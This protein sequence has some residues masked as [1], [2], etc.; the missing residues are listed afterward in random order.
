M[1]KMIQSPAGVLF[2]ESRLKTLRK[3]L[4]LTLESMG[5]KLGVSASALS[6]VERG[7]ANLSQRLATTICAVFPNVSESWL[8]DG[9]GDMFREVS[10]TSGLDKMLDDLSVP[11]VA[12][13]LIRAFAQ[14]PED[15]QAALNVSF[16]RIVREIIRARGLPLPSDLEDAPGTEE[17]ETPEEVPEDI[18]KAA[19]LFQAEAM[20]AK[21]ATDNTASPYP[22]STGTG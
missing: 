10:P 14:L 21:K 15:M 8:L 5:A 11:D 20:E 17:G 16:R 19:A 13:D 12:R 7:A 18:K 6:A 1:D 22:Q 4:G 3:A 9:T 2:L